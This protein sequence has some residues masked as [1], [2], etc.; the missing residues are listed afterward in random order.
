[1]Q[2]LRLLSRHR[3]RQRRSSSTFAIIDKASSHFILNFLT[4]VLWGWSHTF[5][6]CGWCMGLDSGSGFWKYPPPPLLHY[7]CWLSTCKFCNCSANSTPCA[8]VWW[9]WCCCLAHVQM[10][11]TQIHART[12]LYLNVCCFPKMCRPKILWSAFF[13]QGKKSVGKRKLVR[14]CN[15]PKR[16]VIV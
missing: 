10:G 9:W 16:A 7:S 6:N 12:N 4:P 5:T 1:M 3:K 15:N 14:Q 2:F 11:R 8:H 13:F